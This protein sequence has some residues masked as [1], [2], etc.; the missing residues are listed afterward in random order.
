MP[1]STGTATPLLTVKQLAAEFQV[2]QR[3]VWRWIGDGDLVVHRFDR[4]V[5]I[6]PADRDRFLARH[7]DVSSGG[8]ESQ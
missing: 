4:T 1:R 5:R 8:S 3:T 2:S 7:R 6:T